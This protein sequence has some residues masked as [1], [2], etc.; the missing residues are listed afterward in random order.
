[1]SNTDQNTSK[2][3]C[4]KI[5]GRILNNPKIFPTLL[6]DIAVH[7]VKVGSIRVSTYKSKYK[8]KQCKINPLKSV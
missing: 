3:Q 6:S 1:M 4:H 2:E 8:V 5:T 7:I